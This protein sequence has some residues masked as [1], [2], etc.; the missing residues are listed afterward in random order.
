[1]TGLNVI[2]PRAQATGQLWRLAFAAGSLVSFALNAGAV[3][4]EKELK[5]V[6]E[7][8]CLSCHNPNIAKG[9]VI[10]ADAE[11]MFDPE[12][13]FVKRGD[14]LASDLYLVVTPE[15][16]GEKPS[17]PEK[18]DP[19]TEAETELLRQWIDEGAAWPEG[20]VL[21][22]ASKADKSWWAYQPLRKSFEFS[23]S[24]F[25][26]RE[27]PIDVFLEATLKEAGLK[28]NPPADARTLIRRATYDLIGLPPTPGEAADFVKAFQRDPEGAYVAL[29][30]RLLASPHYGER[31]GRH[32]LD[33]VRFGES[34]GYE[35]NQIIDNAWPFRDYVIRSLNEDKPFD[36]FIREHLA[37]DVIGKGKPDIEIGSAFLV[38]GPYD[39]VG[40]QDAAQ[41]AQIRANTLDE[42]ISATGEA[43]LGMTLGCARCHDH[44]FDP[45][46]QRDYYGLY[47][48]FAGVRHGERVL[49]TPKDVDAHQQAIAPL[50]K[51]KADLE[52]QKKAIE[53]AVMD[54]AKKKAADF[55]KRWVR[56]PADRSGTDETFPPVKARFVRL[57]CEGNDSNPS[58]AS[59]FR[60]DEF[61]AWTAGDSPRNVALAANGGKASGAARRIEDFP[62]AYGPQLAIDGKAGA[63]FISAGNDFTVEFAEPVTID[64][65]HFSSAW[66]ELTPEH[67]KFVFVADYRIEVSEDGKQW[68][69]VASGDDRKPVSEAHRQVRW[70]RAE[71]TKAETEKL[72]AL[73]RELAGTDRKIAQLPKLPSV[74][75]GTRNPKDAEGPFHLFVGGSPQRPGADVIPASLSTL[76]AVGPTYELPAGTAETERRLRL[77]D[78][79][80]NPE[81]PL[82]PRVLANRL[83]HYHFGTGIVDTPNDFGYMGGRPV[84]PELLDFL[85]V[86]L[87]ENGWRLKPMH[88]LIMLSRAYRQSSDWQDEAGKVDGDSRLLW[89][90]PPRR[91]SAEEIRDTFLAVSGKLDGRMGG[92]GFRL[93]H[94]MQDNV[95][96]YEPLDEFGPETYR[97]SVYHQNAR[98]SVVDLMTEFDQ[99]DCAFSTPERSETTT[100]LQA[101]T[102]LNHDFTIDMA[103]ALAT[104]LESQAGNDPPS[105]IVEGFRLAYQRDPTLGEL[106]ASLAAVNT[107]GL[108][109]F[110][111]ALLNSSELIFLD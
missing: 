79:I 60:L 88:R 4:F 106:E 59:G 56:S 13:H 107:N 82:T 6:L 40:N 74:W 84:H 21:K 66:N 61:E 47:A 51:Q 19:L 2:F 85:A 5:P 53:T 38:A 58:V 55:E 62:D 23:E 27:N 16:P 22:E 9:D 20:L 33:V 39:D 42:I 11:S 7:K 75:V 24:S 90:F 83:W 109:A 111:R 1:M 34:R 100:P 105:E 99:P 18:G 104:R 97:R 30:D 41:A 25:Q 73:S 95:S 57:V 28:M 12:A 29:I 14:A 50:E 65:V 92:P 31:W 37:G 45:I 108:R 101:L 93:Y 35:R 110:C 98:A 76:S 64:R 87:E 96:T 17:M 44:K 102:M 68:T 71:I 67:R 36:Q 43:F 91:L 70:R 78:W 52:A 81:N 89:R 103:E 54:R 94:Y 80:V 15:E 63:R 72:A 32:W 77:A 10:L 49:A 48:T 86:K 3:D 69:E 46:T 26:E 8:K